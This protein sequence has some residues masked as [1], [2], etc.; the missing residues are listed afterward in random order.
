M[1]RDIIAN[2]LFRDGECILTD[3]GYVFDMGRI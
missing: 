2:E 1:P 3:S